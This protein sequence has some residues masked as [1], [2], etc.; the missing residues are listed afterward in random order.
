[1]LFLSIFLVIRNFGLDIIYV[2]GLSNVNRFSV[3]VK[4][5]LV[6]LTATFRID[7]SSTRIGFISDGH[8]EP[9]WMFS[10]NRYSNL[11]SIV[12]AIYGATLKNSS[13]TSWINIAL[14]HSY[15]QG[16]SEN[17]GARNLIE[18]IPRAIVVIT[19]MIIDVSAV[20]DNNNISTFILGLGENITSRDVQ[21]FATSKRVLARLS[22]NANLH[23]L[24]EFQEAVSNDLERGK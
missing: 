20:K 24:I 14:N 22:I 3:P 11:S 21:M 4:Q 9:F 19:D 17:N 15:S 5:L 7:E 23:E 18:G 6:N 8:E 13:N 12:P 16:F 2:V 1:M 10:L